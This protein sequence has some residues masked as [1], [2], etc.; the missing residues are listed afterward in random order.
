MVL[1][2]EF[3]GKRP[4]LFQ[5]TSTTDQVYADADYFG[6]V[7][8]WIHFGGKTS[9]GIPGIQWQADITVDPGGAGS[10]C[11][12]QLLRP[13]RTIVLNS[14]TILRWATGA[15]FVLDTVMPYSGTWPIPVGNTINFASQD[16]P[17]TGLTPAYTSSS[18]EYTICARVECPSELSFVHLGKVRY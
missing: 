15:E 9:T 4:F 10:I 3:P 1:R 16:S 14:G 8:T 11:Y 17:G 7:G 5:F 2:Q 18:A 6:G 12:I 13:N